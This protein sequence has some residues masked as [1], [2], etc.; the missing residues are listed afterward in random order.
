MSMTNANS[1]LG[2]LI[3]DNIKFFTPSQ[4]SNCMNRV[5]ETFTITIKPTYKQHCAIQALAEGGLPI[6]ING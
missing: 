5:I 2:L 4:K 3:G 1:T 6:I